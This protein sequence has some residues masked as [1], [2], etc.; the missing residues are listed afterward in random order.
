[1]GEGDKE[2]EFITDS[3]QLVHCLQ[4]PDQN[5]HTHTP[6]GNHS[7]NPTKLNEDEH[8]HTHTQLHRR[9]HA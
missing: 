7:N 2:I 8:T 1:M 9:T 6:L 4:L 3:E 5:T